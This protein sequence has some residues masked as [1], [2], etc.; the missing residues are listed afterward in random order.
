MITRFSQDEVRKNLK[1]APLIDA[2]DERFA[3]GRGC[4]V[5]PVDSDLLEPYYYAT[6]YTVY[7]DWA[8]ILLVFLSK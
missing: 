6:R 5:K 2:I 1:V 4:P 8:I 3:R 7:T